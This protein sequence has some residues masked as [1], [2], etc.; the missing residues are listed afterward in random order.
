MKRL[1]LVL[2]VI[3]VLFFLWWQLGTSDDQV[4]RQS[5]TI[6]DSTQSLVLLSEADKAKAS[7]QGEI[8][9]E[10]SKS[11]ET[12]SDTITSKIKEGCYLF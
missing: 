11:S 3:N 1:F 12:A 6:S 5:Q 9:Q 10:S 2:L 8:N 4:M 7:Q